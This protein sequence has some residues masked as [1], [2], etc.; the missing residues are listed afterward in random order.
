MS[1]KKGGPAAHHYTRCLVRLHSV[2]VIQLLLFIKLRHCQEPVIRS[3]PDPGYVQTAYVSALIPGFTL[4]FFIPEAI[5]A[6]TAFVLCQHL[7]KTDVFLHFILIYI[8]A[9]AVRAALD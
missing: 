3:L 4:V 7:C 2:P 5:A 6:L 8:C 9:V 1:T